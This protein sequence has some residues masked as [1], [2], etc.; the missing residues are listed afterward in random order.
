MEALVTG[1]N[2]GI[3]LALVKRLLNES[4]F[5]RI[6]ATAR[7][8]SS[9][10]DLSS[11]DSSRV[12]VLPLDVT[13]DSSCASLA[14]S[15][16]SKNAKLSLVWNNSGVLP[17][18]ASILDADASVVQS[19]FDVNSTGPLRVTQALMRK[20][21]LRLESP[22]DDMNKNTLSMTIVANM[23]SGVGSIADNNSGGM[24]GYRMSKAAINMFAVTLGREFEKKG[25]NA[26]SLAIT[27]GWVQTEMTNNTGT[28]TVDQCADNLTNKIN[29]LTIADNAKYFN[30]KGEEFAW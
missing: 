23:S 29:S 5:S 27:P 21:V 6:F 3:G 25:F 19:T 30:S 20:N 2:R 9:A 24:Y 11:L 28:L 15:L 16:S 7:D 12:V 14:D 8:I 4:K 13:S 18:Q 22:S 10:K 26:I 1:A 17:R